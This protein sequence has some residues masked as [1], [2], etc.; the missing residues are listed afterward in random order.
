[1]H[2]IWTCVSAV[3]GT[4]LSSSFPF[5]FYYYYYYYYFQLEPFVVCRVACHPR[6]YILLCLTVKAVQS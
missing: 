1:M 6:P 2:I 3:D 5:F 4:F